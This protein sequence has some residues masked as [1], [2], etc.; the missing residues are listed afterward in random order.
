MELG[1]E[2]FLSACIGAATSKARTG[3]PGRQ[4]TPPHSSAADPAASTVSDMVDPWLSLIASSTACES[5]ATA[6]AA[7]SVSTRF[8]NIGL[9]RRISSSRA[10]ILADFCSTLPPRS[11]Y[12]GQL[13]PEP[14]VL[15]QLR[16]NGTIVSRTE[17][18]LRS[19]GDKLCCRWRQSPDDPNIYFG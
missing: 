12:G 2:F 4:S 9:S 3:V 10:I 7:A 13:S 19:I 14:K 17:V 11:S 5:A 1:V 6:I 15:G 16:Y 8:L 18:Q